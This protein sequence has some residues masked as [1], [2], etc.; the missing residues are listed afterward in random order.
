MG[1]RKKAT[2]LF[3]AYPVVWVLSVAVFWLFMGGSDAMGYALVFV[4]LLN[5]V[6]L[7]AVSFLMGRR[8]GWRGRAWVAPV[9]LGALYALL[10]YATFSLANT[11]SSGNLHAPDAG[12]ALVGVLVS[13]IGLCLGALVCRRSKSADRCQRN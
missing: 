12:L 6:A 8:L 9:A 3:V 13:A 5:P 4:W 2:G 1:E 11:L 10:P 7:L